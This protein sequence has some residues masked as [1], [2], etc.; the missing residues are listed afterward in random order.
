MKK[1]S[2]I[3]GSLILIVSAVIAK[4]AGALFKI[5][6]T[7]MLGG[8]GM[9]YFSCAYGLFLPIYALTANGLTTAAAKLTADNCAAGNYRNARKIYRVSL[10]F[11]KR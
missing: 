10:L 4:A 3:K 9:G 11:L 1:Q 6:L 5:P 7:N 2:F 8:T